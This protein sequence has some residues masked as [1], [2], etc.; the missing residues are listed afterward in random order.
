M[1]KKKCW[2]LCFLDRV[3]QLKPIFLTPLLLCLIS[4]NG[5][6][7]NNVEEEVQELVVTGVV[8]SEEDGM[9]IVGVNVILKD[10]NTGAITDFDG[11]YSI[12]VPSGKS[13]LIF[14]SLG[15]VKTQVVVGGQ[16]TI[17][18]ALKADVSQLDEVV[19][20]GYGTAKKETLTGSIEQ[21][22]SDKFEDL[23]V[24]NPALSLQGA[25][26]GL[27]V[28]R[29]SSRPG[30]EG[31]GMQIRGTSSVNGI[32]PLIVIDGVPVLSNNSFYDMNPDDI[33]AIS[34]LKGGSAS[35]YGSRAAG[36]VILV[37][38][39]K[40]KGKTKVVA[41]TV[42]RLGTVGIRPPT[43]TM[44]QYANI[45]LEASS[46]DSNPD[47]FFWN[48]SALEKMASGY[49]GIYELGGRLGNIHLSN[50]NIFDQMYG[51][52]YSNQHNLSVSGG[53]DKSNY[54]VGLSYDQNVGGLKTAYD[55]TEKYNFLVN[56][57]YD[58]SEKLSFNTNISYFFKDFSGPS[59]GLNA[60]SIT[61]D[62]PLFAAQNPYGQWY[63]NFGVVGGGKNAIANSA[64]GGR[65]N[66]EREQL[67]IALSAD[68]KITD[69]LSFSGS[70]AYARD[71]QNYQKYVLNVKTYG[72]FGTPA[73]SSINPTPYIF[74]EMNMGTYKN[75]K[76]AFN[77][78]KSLRDHNV[79]GLLAAEGELKT[80][81]HLD[82]RRN[83][84]EDYG[85]YDLNLGSTDLIV[86]NNG[87]AGTWGFFGYIGRLNYDY[88]G[89]Y[90]LELQG[91]RDGASRFADGYKWS[92]YGSISG[93]WVVSNEKFLRDSN[94]ISF[95]KVRGGYG[96]LGSTSGIN[97]FSYLSGVSFG[98][99][100]FG[101]TAGLQNTAKADGL[102]STT[103]TWER[104]VTSEFGVDFKLFNNKMFGSV[105]FYKKD[106]I[107]MLIR[108]VYP[109]V[110]GASAPY[111]NI[112]NLETAGWEAVLGWKDTVGDFSYSISA[113]MSDTKNI[114][115]KYEG[116]QTIVAGLNDAGNGEILQHYPINSYFMYET[117]GFFENQAA[118]DSY[119][120]TYTGGGSNG[121]VPSQ[122]SSTVSLRPGD[123]RIVD[124]N[125]DKVINSEDLVYKGDA[126]PHYVYGLNL[127]AQ[128]KNFDISAFFQGVLDQ[129]I[130]RTGYFAYPFGAVYQNQSTAFMGKTWSESQPNSQYP[131]TST[132]ATRTAWNFANKD[133]MLQNNR[134]LRL[135]TLV[136]GY[137]IKALKIA[138]TEIDNLRIYF[139]GNDLFEFTSLDD[140]YD[141]EASANSNSSSYPFMRTWALGVKLSI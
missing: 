85:V 115:T 78:S 127:N 118:V 141:P 17:N 82:G 70:F 9:P 93:G 56:Y 2:S 20:I 129:N 86:T 16:S 30:S 29:N 102:T 91:R 47:Y 35:I 5:Y 65:V 94:I 61:Y 55:G 37:T 132:N 97:T 3:K 54:R 15:F 112:G 125:G 137:N 26:P 107:G 33:E 36:G 128:Y 52:A 133:F 40:G 106:N 119:Y 57:G 67:K 108:G 14:S 81:K 72:W 77:Y 75:F 50:A 130:L 19:V 42:F 116:G 135:K 88:K 111:T 131:R 68:Y 22:K 58:I 44:Q 73:N 43:P 6:A 7:N 1:R 117:N 87:G 121:L 104:I 63:G 13:V 103:T 136:L 34:I 96:E 139:S 21:I 140:G 109:S 98:D 80:S 114:I 79:S 41:S 64:E 48:K 76:G 32:A 25:S 69:D 71:Y 100:V 99:T 60:N 59:G 89:T 51:D 84:F 134:Y 74:E 38:T 113:N 28:T 90:L 11:H 39:K 126:S 66:D 53:T 62:A 124:T 45:F 92:N 18:V 101:S 120:A 105:D 46:Q 10:S 12:K 4:V 110:V 27:V 138:N 83:G 31:L 23:A 8:T 122:L 24:T 95:L 123:S 49:E